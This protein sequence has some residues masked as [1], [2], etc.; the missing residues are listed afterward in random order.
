MV[1]LPGG[2]ATRH[3]VD[4]AVLEALGPHGILINVGRG[5]VVDEAALVAA[6]DKG[7]IHSA[8]L[9]VFEDEPNVHPGLLERDGRA[10]A[11]CG[12][13]L[14]GYSRRHGRSCRWTTSSLGWPAVRRSTPVPETPVPARR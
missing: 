10:A 6:L 4:A 3:L 2:A 5:S 8:G 11:A 7:T 12:L 1:V 14:R 13:G 9:D